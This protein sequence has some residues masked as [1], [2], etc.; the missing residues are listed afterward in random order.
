MRA[1]YAKSGQPD[2]SVAW[3]YDLA[4]NTTSSDATPT[5]TNTFG[6][7]ELN[8]KTSETGQGPGGDHRLCL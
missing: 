7:D 1:V 5:A 4:G 8:R 3:D 2:Q 6:Y